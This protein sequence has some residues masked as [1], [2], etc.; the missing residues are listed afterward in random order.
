MAFFTLFKDHLHTQHRPGRCSLQS[1]H[2]SVRQPELMDLS[3][4]RQTACCQ[5]CS[6]QPDNAAQCTSRLFPKKDILEQARSDTESNN[7]RSRA[8]E[9]DLVHSESDH[10]RPIQGFGQCMRLTGHTNRLM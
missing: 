4:D 7:S 8:N 6:V 9:H 1:L 2:L 10:Q 3:A 5:L